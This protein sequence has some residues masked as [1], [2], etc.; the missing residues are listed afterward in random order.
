MGTTT[1]QSKSRRIELILK[2]IDTLPT[3][4]TVATRLLSVTASDDSNAKEVID[5]VSA[6]PALTAKIL[7]MCKGA[8][9]GLRSEAMTVDKAVV[10]LG[11]NAIRNAVLSIKVFELFDDEPQ[12]PMENEGSITDRLLGSQLPKFDTKEFWRHSLAV[13]VAAEQIA[14]AH[15]SGDLPPAEAF[16]CG[17]LHDVGK[18]SMYHVLP[19]SYARVIELVGQHQGSICEFERRIVGIDHHTAGKRLAEQWQL[20]FRLQDCIW[21]HGSPYSALPQL[22]HKRLVGLISLADQIVRRQHI[23]YSGNFSFREHPHDL[24][25]ELG[26][27]PKVVAECT[28]D[29]HEQVLKRGEMLGLDD[30]PSHEMFMRSIQQANEMLGRLNGM[31]DDRSRRAARQAKLL[32]AIT[33]F[34]D[35]ATPGRTVTAVMGAVVQ[36]AAHLLGAGYYAGLYQQGEDEAWQLYQYNDHGEV[37]HSELIEPR[38]PGGTCLRW[39]PDNTRPSV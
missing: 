12:R 28:T 7:S 11:F 25:E 38:K 2:Q 30:E 23:G 27:N 10:L 31:L 35:E 6:D 21:L 19:R 34:H 37:I 26:L 16:V 32:D 33:T 14:T 3:L 15:P 1:D 4:P 20:P 8:S 24:A 29:L 17:L 13:A 18:L 22:E 39:I 5:L 9:H 36:N